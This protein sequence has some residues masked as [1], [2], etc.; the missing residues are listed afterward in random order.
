MHFW[1]R[2]GQIDRHTTRGRWTGI[3]RVA[4]HSDDPQG[5][6]P[7]GRWRR[8]GD[9]FLHCDDGH[10][11]WGLYGAAGAL[12]VIQDDRGVEALMQLTHAAPVGPGAR[13]RY[14]VV[15]RRRH[16]PG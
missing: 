4:A 10:V 12:F 7:T 5:R 16:D 9:G 8:S 6:G 1:R 2:S 11:R 3:V 15:P 13:G 14:V